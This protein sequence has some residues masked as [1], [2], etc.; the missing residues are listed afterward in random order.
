MEVT[1]AEIT[2]AWEGLVAQAKQKKEPLPEEARVRWTVPCIS[3][4]L[5]CTSI[6]EFCV[7]VYLATVQ[8]SSIS[9]TGLTV[10]NSLHIY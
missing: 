6:L 10:A 5:Y 8:A 4:Y 9:N 7:L 2:S 3:L 1:D